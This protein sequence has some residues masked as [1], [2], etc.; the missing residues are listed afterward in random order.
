MSDQLGLYNGDNTNGGDTNTPDNRSLV[1]QYTGDSQTQINNEDINSNLMAALAAAGDASRS[2]TI[3]YIGT[4][5]VVTT[6]TGDIDLYARE[7]IYFL[8]VAGSVSAG[9][10]AFGVAV[11]I[12]VV[13]SNVEAYVMRQSALNAGNDINVQAK[14]TSDMGAHAIA[15]NFSASGSTGAQVT[16][17]V[18]LGSQR[19]S[20]GELSTSTADAVTINSARNILVQASATRSIMADAS[21]GNISFGGA[22]YGAAIAVSTVLGTTQAYVG[23]V[24]VGKASGQ[25]VRSLTVKS[26]SDITSSQTWTIN[27]SVGGVALGG[28]IAINVTQPV[29]RAFIYNLADIR[30][31]ADVSVIAIARASA[32]SNAPG[33]NV[34]AFAAG[35][36][37]AITILSPTIEAYI[38]SA[39]ITAANI[40]V[41]T[42]YNYDDTGTSKVV[43]GAW[44]LAI[45]AGGGL[46]AIQGTVAVARSN[47]QVKTYIDGHLDGATGNSTLTASSGTISLQSIVY[48]QAK[49]EAWGITVGGFTA[50]I[51]L[52][53]A[54]SDG[55]DYQ[56][57]IKYATI[58]SNNVALD[59]RVAERVYSQVYAGSAAVYGGMLNIAV[60]HQSPSIKS[61]ID[62]SATNIVTSGNMAV[63]AQFDADAETKVV[64]VSVSLYVS[65]AASVAVATSH[66]TVEASIKAGLLA[67]GGGLTVEARQNTNQNGTQVSTGA[68][69]YS[70]ASGGGLL[71]GNGAVAYATLTPTVSA[72]ISGTSLTATGNI[73][74]HAIAYNKSY[75]EAEGITVSGAG[76]G[77]SVARSTSQGSTTAYLGSSLARSGNAPAVG[78]LLIQ[79]DTY[80]DAYAET[81]MGVGGI[82]AGGGSSA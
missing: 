66:P 46:G 5:A 31:T 79:A 27:L 57:Y 44:A 30:T 8:G 74:I 4:G 18:D 7:R 32:F 26:I 47:V 22:A 67:I 81:L 29:S 58:R 52:A 16:V 19:A 64:G 43:Q 10:S 6:E 34:G 39:T 80:D 71:S 20:I 73:T 69:S 41:K 17:F 1:G 40:Y 54:L 51:N 50:S 9:G 62:G 24:S 78:D 59:N 25:T 82:I 49:A 48:N 2:G 63:R 21:G 60:S 14:L 12:N 45:G 36:S 68:K 28:A 76:I 15:G 42:I 56:T 3:V 13:G 72:Y 38:G 11:S 35:L 33:V 70:N 55:S 53:V 77:A 61:F 23:V 37:V 75:A 65:L